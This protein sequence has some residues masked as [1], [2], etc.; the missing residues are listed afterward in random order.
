MQAS[1]QATPNRRE[2]FLSSS[3]TTSGREEA[4]GG[5]RD[6]NKKEDDELAP[7]IPVVRAAAQATPPAAPVVAVEPPLPAGVT[8]SELEQANKTVWTT[9]GEASGLAAWARKWSAAAVREM[10]GEKGGKEE[11]EEDSSSLDKKRAGSD[12]KETMSVS[13]FVCFASVL[14]NTKLTLTRARM[15]IYLSPLAQRHPRLCPR[16]I[17]LL[18][19]PSV[20]HAQLALGPFDPLIC[21]VD[22]YG[23]RRRRR[24]SRR[25]CAAADVD[26]RSSGRSE[27]VSPPLVDFC[28]SLSS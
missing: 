28:G 12:W 9:L 15:V 19:C 11:E 2:A 25:R 10:G 1:A 22:H 4:V 3:S 23:N 14:P 8:L 24:R 6:G 21:D 26:A 7:P 20:K 16:R 13:L 27:V 18:L 5:L 17:G